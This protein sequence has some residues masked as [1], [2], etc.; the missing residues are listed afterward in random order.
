[1]RAAGLTPTDHPV[2]GAG[3]PVA[4][5][6]RWLFTARVGLDTHP[7]LADH[8][9][10]GTV[11]LPGAAL[12][13]LTIAAGAQA[14][15]AVL[16]ELALEAPVVLAAE[17]AVQLQLALAAPAADGTRAVT[18]H[19]RPEPAGEEPGEAWT[20]VA[21]GR[22]ALA[23]DRAAAPAPLE[24][25]WPTE[26]ATP[27][28]AEELYDQLADAGLAYGPAFRG[29]HAAWRDGDAI[30]A[31]VE[32]AEAERA[33]APR[34]GVHP[35]LLDAGLH[36]AALAA[37]GSETRV[38]FAWRGVALHDGAGAPA[39]RV[40]LTATGD[41][42]ALTAW[43]ADGRPVVQV[44][45]LTTRPLDPALL[46]T[47]GTRREDD[48]LRLRWVEVPS[49]AGRGDTAT[50]GAGRPEDGTRRDRGAAGARRPED[51]A[52][53][54]TVPDVLLLEP[55][56]ARDPT[57]AAMA[58]EAAPHDGGLAGATHAATR[59][60]LA[61]VRAALADERL[62]SARLV[63]VT[64]GAVATT[65]A[66]RPD[67]AAAAVWGLV[68]SAQSEHLGRLTL[69]DLP[70]GADPAAA[71]AALP[72][73]E[74]QLAAR[75]DALL[76]PR[77]TAVPA[78]ARAAPGG[79]WHVAVREPGSLDGLAVVEDEPV[80]L[81]TGQVRVALRAAGL[82]FRDV[83]ITLGL[84]P[85]AA[86][87]GS[88]GAGVVAEVGPGVDDLEVGDRVLGLVVDGFGPSAVADA[89]GLVGLPDG[90]DWARAASV[91]I[92]YLT[93]AYALR[94]LAALR[95]GERVLVHNGAGGVGMAAIQLAQHLGAEVFATASP[96]KWD[97]LRGL[98]LPDTH[99]A[100]SRDPG[101]RDAVLEATGGEGVDVV[102]DALAGDLV[103]A[104]LELLPRGGRFL[105][106]GKTDVRDPDAV[107]RDHPGVRYRAF[108][109]VEAGPERLAELLRDVVSSL[110][111]GDLGGLPVRCWDVRDAAEAMRH[112]REARHVG[113]VVLTIPQA[114]DPQGTV[115]VTGGTGTLGA[116]TAEH[117]VRAH[118]AR[119][120]LL[121]SRRGP[122]AEGATA[123][124]ERLAELGAS[125]E[126]VACD[127]ADRAALAAVL[128]AVPAEHPLTAVVHVAGV[129]DDAVL[130]ELGD[131]QL[132]RV[133]RPKVDAASHLHELTRGADLAAWV[134]FSSASGTLGGPGQA[135]YAAANAFL[136]ALAEA[137]RA[138]GL[139][140]TSLA[141]GLWEEASGITGSLA[142]ADR[143]R[144]ARSGLLPLAT[145]EALG[146]IDAGLASAGGTVV[147]LRLDRRVLREHAR[148]G[149]LP[150]LLR[151]L[152]RT[153]IRRQATGSLARQLAEA[154]EGGRDRLVLDLVRTHVAAILGHPG[155]DAV[156][157]ERP[158]KE[159]GFDS[160][161]AVEL[162]N[163]LAQATGVTLAATTVFDHPTPA[164][165][166]AY[167]RREA[168]GSGEQ[169]PA[170]A[171]VRT[172][173]DEP[174]AIVGV[175]CR[176]PGG[177]RSAEDLWRLVDA[178]RDAIGPFPDDRGWDLEALY[179]PDP[180]RVGT[181]YVREGGFLGDA[182]DFDARFFGISPREALAMDPQQRL[183][184][185]VAWDA[186]ADAGLD[187]AALRGTPAGVF[188]GVMGRDY[189]NGAHIPDELEG[190]MATG[191]A[192]Q[193]RLRARGV[194]VRAGGPGDDGRHGVLV[195][196]GR[197]APGRPGAARGRVRPGAGRRGHG[198]VDAGAVRGVQ[199]PGRAGARRAVQVVRRG[200]G[201]DDV[202][203]GLRAARAGTALGRAPQ[204]AR[205]PRRHPRQRGQPGRRVE[206]ADGAERAVAGAGDPPGAGQRRAVARGRR[207][208]RGARHRD[209]ARRPDRGAGA[210]RDLR[211][212]AARR[213]AAAA[214][215]DQ[216][217]RRPHRRGGG[218]RRR[219]Q[220]R[221]GAAARA[222]AA[223]A[224][225][226]RAVTPRRLGR[227]RRGAADRGPA[228]GGER[229][230]AARGG[231]V[232]RRLGDQRPRDRRGGA[233]GAP[234]A[235]RGAAVAGRAVGAVRPRRG[236]LA[237]AGARAR[238]AP[239]A[240]PGAGAGGRGA[241]ARGARAPGGSGGR[242]RRRPRRA[243]GGRA[244]AGRRVAGGRPGA[245]ARDAWRSCAAVRGRSGRGW[246]S[247]WRRSRRCSPR[248]SARA[249][250]R[251]RRTST[252]GSRTCSATPRRSSGSRSSSP[253][254]GR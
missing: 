133:L 60:A 204:R 177:V 253:R 17:T 100:S 154:P 172:R 225:R 186:L 106:M 114:L 209:D 78:A 179:D 5:E 84:Y 105:E 108:D 249:G 73:D 136:D 144:I 132:A 42:V 222:D 24:G 86:T 175:G 117:L 227:G 69:L 235:G 66:E 148:A 82:N 210:A 212:G 122:E 176:Y 244:V 128:D 77:L 14:G 87:I 104:S 202:V 146:L 19:A 101:F 9:V 158:F 142:D 237:R 23:A 245:R 208:G 46:R 32:L 3:V 47:A 248:R 226:R 181:S 37:E 198:D 7:W 166:A 99:I 120:L 102:L 58:P 68:R 251:W 159:L 2:L 250:R 29:V 194:R 254:C 116:R 192:G 138:E 219:H 53:L 242:R 21:T 49:A 70:P 6:D 28:D 113:K 39:V 27:V 62:A 43:D 103:D 65:G 216:V 236:R 163:R 230:A 191:I 182:F 38:P 75:G 215:V 97:V 200:G 168:E 187:P 232:V 8:T 83:L 228:V 149:V 152:V 12:V 111:A 238:R 221:A 169:A 96:A 89:R 140:A 135:N 92:V 40:R 127:A 126:V 218:R 252:G 153:T 121:T 155:P 211:P 205:R 229:P 115:L 156:D 41:E 247:R 56:V 164:A 79:P 50:A 1:V 183:L 185:E 190:Y 197:P 184:L 91:P 203:G 81:G 63:V 71:V 88:E 167:L 151:G 59:A 170:A 95:A 239:R 195:V 125:A 178:G 193:R 93:A 15:T 201:R 180:Q 217:E 174:I 161:A 207:P 220:G 233:A 52:T 137:R 25:A 4:D 16:D 45:G 231:L 157:P 188:T 11:L 44:D 48:L 94:D 74:P 139:P 224:P 76:A 34:F 214:R 171:A 64:R 57:P 90:W 223:H 67:P 243:R 61:L 55:P 165:V 20:T 118:G 107:A 51:L 35:A 110:D 145:E 189:G 18:V 112:M 129:V 13:E 141:W 109:V 31:E 143:A 131:E 10:G 54:D 213:T 196:A 22:L 246:R 130:T 36:A 206:R 134:T 26:A 30:L 119:R 124:V 85:G 199:P 72:D 123:L 241:V 160:L 98:G 173:A 162:R 147:P 240:S 80:A 33:D 234:P 150:P